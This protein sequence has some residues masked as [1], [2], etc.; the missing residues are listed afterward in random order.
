MEHENMRMIQKKIDASNSYM[1]PGHYR[2][3]IFGAM[4]SWAGVV[5]NPSCRIACTKSAFCSGF[6][7][8]AAN[9]LLVSFM[10][11]PLYALT[12]MI[13]VLAFLLFVLL[14]YLAAP[15][16]STMGMC[17]SIKMQSNSMSHKHLVGAM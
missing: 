17:R 14:I 7:K 6:A 9:R 8:E 12:A 1:N 15:S 16:P 3:S 5:L 10:S 4:R 13:G 11:V 2:A